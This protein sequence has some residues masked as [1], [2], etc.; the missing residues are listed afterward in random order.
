MGDARGRV[1][2]WDLPDW[3]LRA[4]HSFGRDRPMLVHMLK[5]EQHYLFVPDYNEI[6][7]VS[8]R[9][10]TTVHAFGNLWDADAAYVAGDVLLIVNRR[11]ASCGPS[12]HRRRG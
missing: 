2:I 8:L 1:L 5:D 10:G 12:Q 6:R 7:I 11:G 3:R 9:S 4:V